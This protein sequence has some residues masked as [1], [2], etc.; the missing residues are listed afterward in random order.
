MNKEKIR[1]IL[2]FCFDK[3]EEATQAAKIE[4]EV[5]GPDT[6][7]ENNAQFWFRR[8]RSGNSDVK[9]AAPSGRPVA[10]NV[11]EIMEK[12]N[13]DRHISRV[14]IAKELKISHTS[15]LDH[16]RKAGYTKKLDNREEVSSIETT[17][18][19]IRHW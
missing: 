18:G 16:L 1:Y 14:E 4:E 11:G 2:Q 3:D 9:D 13:E 17:L 12:V 15:V 5:Y 7:T 8:F 6:L 19:R 10:I